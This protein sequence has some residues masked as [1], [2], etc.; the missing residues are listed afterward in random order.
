MHCAV[1]LSLHYQHMCLSAVNVTLCTFFFSFSYAFLTISTMFLGVLLWSPMYL[2]IPSFTFAPFSLSLFLHLHSL[3]LFS[4]PSLCRL[5]PSDIF[6]CRM[7][8]WY[9]PSS[10]R[11]P[12]APPPRWVSMPP[13]QCSSSRKCWPNISKVLFSSIGRWA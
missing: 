7:W 11:L 3:Y 6:P 13:S 9:W 1:C 5:C 10:G 12:P 2:N 8:T 4:T